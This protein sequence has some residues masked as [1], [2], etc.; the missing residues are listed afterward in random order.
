MALIQNNSNIL[1]NM[2]I[3]KSESMRSYDVCPSNL[4][5]LELG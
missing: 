5:G 4:T 1:L 2:H 3:S